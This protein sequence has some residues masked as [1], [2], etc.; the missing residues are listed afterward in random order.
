MDENCTFI[1]FQRNPADSHVRAFHWYWWVWETSKMPIV[2]YR[3][4]ASI[5][6]F[7]SF[8]LSR[9]GEHCHREKNRCWDFHE[10][11]RFEVPGVRKSG[12]KKC[13]VYSVTVAGDESASGI[14]MK[15]GIW[16]KG[17]TEM[18][19]FG[20]L[21]NKRSNGGGLLGDVLAYLQIFR[22]P[23]YGFW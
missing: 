13:R 21:C 8:I 15:L 22:N 14:Q 18:R 9:Y 3:K 17:R 11:S 19:F 16:D 2:G 10:S 23:L 1:S 5:A 7:F 6:P 4:R 12:L 20:V